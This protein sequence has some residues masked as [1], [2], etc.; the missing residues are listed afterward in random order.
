MQIVIVS[1][2]RHAPTLLARALEQRTIAAQF[3]CSLDEAGSLAAAYP[4]DL[5]LVDRAVLG[6]DPAALRRFRRR[7]A[8]LPVVV[9]GSAIAAADGV[10]LF[11]DGIDD[12]FDMPMPPEVMAARIRAIVRRCRGCDGSAMEIGPLRFDMIRRSLTRD[13]TPVPLTATEY[14][15]LE[16][17]LTRRGSTLSKEALLD[18]V[19][20][21]DDAPMLRI[22]DVY[23]CRLRKKLAE[24]GA[25]DV[26]ATVRGLGYGI[27]PARAGSRPAGRVRPDG[28]PV[29]AATAA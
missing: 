24:H 11:A 25:S 17:L 5:V 6:P 19:Y 29:H 18:H 20:G 9:F 13:G 10:S 7:E 8:D 23:V 21:A 15:I 22:I 12:L 1:S 16:A 27:V 14:R 26:I 4:L 2:A 28:L 3:C